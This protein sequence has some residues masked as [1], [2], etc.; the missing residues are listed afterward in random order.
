M[1]N[2][3]L[4]RLAFNVGLPFLMN[5][6]FKFSIGGGARLSCPVKGMDDP[7]LNGGPDKQVPPKRVPSKKVPPKLGGARLSCPVN[8]NGL[9]N[10]EQRT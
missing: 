3:I 6:P 7:A 9:L 1:V 2:P 4:I 5:K 8:G 10:V